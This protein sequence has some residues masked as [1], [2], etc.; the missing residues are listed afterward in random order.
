[1]KVSLRKVRCD[2]PSVAMG[3]IAFNLLVFLFILA[4]TDDDSH[5]EW[6]PATAVSVQPIGVAPVSVI[7]DKDSRLYLNG[8]QIAVSSLSGAVAEKL[9]DSPAGQRRVVLKVDR[10]ALASRFEPVIAAVAEAGGELVH[11][12]QDEK[13][14]R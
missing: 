2:V 11:V 12:L 10:E 3:D 9:G 5:V 6:R 1:M 7:I 13:A 4:R 14:E 8:Q